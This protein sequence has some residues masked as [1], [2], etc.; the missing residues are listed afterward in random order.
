MLPSLSTLSIRD[1]ASVKCGKPANIGMDPSQDI[2][3]L[4]L[5]TL[6]HF[7][8]ERAFERDMEEQIAA[9]RREIAQVYNG[10]K[11]YQ[12]NHHNV[13]LPEGFQKLHTRITHFGENATSGMWNAMTHNQRLFYVM[14]FSSQ[15]RPVVLYLLQIWHWFL[16]RLPEKLVMTFNPLTDA[17]VHKL[18]AD[19]VRRVLDKKLASGLDERINSDDITVKTS[20]NYTA[21]MKLVTVYQY[22]NKNI[23]NI[24]FGDSEDNE[25]LTPLLVDAMHRASNHI[26]TKFFPSSVVV[27]IEH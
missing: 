8:A 12:N 11:S 20:E 4:D 14:A 26:T 25:S 10:L 6:A 1:D 18:W 17:N 9:K 21:L 27:N 5:T 15:S 7:A 3:T 13:P 16:S 19:L 23:L 24:K 2:D 22:V